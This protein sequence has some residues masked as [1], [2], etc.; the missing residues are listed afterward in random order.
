M[1]FHMVKVL[2]CLHFV[3]HDI[4]YPRI[5]NKIIRIFSNK[6]LTSMLNASALR[7]EPWSISLQTSSRQMLIQEL[8]LSFLWLLC[9]FHSSLKYTNSDGVYAYVDSDSFPDIIHLAKVEFIWILEILCNYLL[10]YL[11]FQFALNG[12]FVTLSNMQ[13]YVARSVPH[14]GLSLHQPPEVLLWSCCIADKEKYFVN[15]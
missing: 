6:H 15:K 2:L 5:N 4:F 3:S 11:R 8:R 13:R 7:T 1:L 14:C 10:L 12:A 9:H